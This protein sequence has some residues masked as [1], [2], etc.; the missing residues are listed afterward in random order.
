[1]R[2]CRRCGV[3]KNLSDF[4]FTYKKPE[5][6]RTV[7]KACRQERRWQTYQPKT[8]RRRKGD[9]LLCRQCRVALVLGENWYA[10]QRRKHEY[11]CLC[12]RSANRKQRRM[13]RPEHIKEQ[14]HASYLRTRDYVLAKA[15]QYRDKHKEQ[16]YET[17]QRWKHRSPDRVAHYSAHA[18]AKRKG[19]DG[20][21]TD[22][23]WQMYLA[24][25]EHKCLACGSD[26]L[27]TKDHILPLTKGGTDHIHNIQPLCQSCNSRKRDQFINYW[28]PPG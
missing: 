25:A 28:F 21:H 7:C 14:K 1:M 17:I 23:E 16:V 12:C 11:L 20:S 6:R 27:L 10:S 9:P 26:G 8:T 19:A 4:E 15:K 5:A 3:A 22:A 13:L 24:M 18:Y 2:T